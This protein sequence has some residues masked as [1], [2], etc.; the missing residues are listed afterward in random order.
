[1]KMRVDWWLCEICGKSRGR[2]M[3]HSKCSKIIQANH[4][5]DMAQPI[6]ETS[7]VGLT[8]QHQRNSKYK[9]TA[10]RYK[11]GDWSE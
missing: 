5:D 3:N 10:K 7:L 1:M 6:D 2:G 8:K 9:Q 11:N 4:K